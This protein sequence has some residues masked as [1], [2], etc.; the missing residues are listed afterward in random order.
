M[1]PPW[2]RAGRLPAMRRR[3]PMCRRCKPRWPP[4]CNRWM[5]RCRPGCRAAIS[6]A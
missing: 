5:R 6:T 4:P 1:A 3:T 2:A